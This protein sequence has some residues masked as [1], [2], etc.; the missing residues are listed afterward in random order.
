MQSFPVYPGD[1]G[2]YYTHI[3]ENMYLTLSKPPGPFPYPG[4]V[5]EITNG[6]G[7]FLFATHR[8]QD[9]PYLNRL[10]W[11]KFYQSL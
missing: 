10:G 8:E 1:I 2:R 3:G 9:I 4:D 11:K 7:G 5:I 6:T